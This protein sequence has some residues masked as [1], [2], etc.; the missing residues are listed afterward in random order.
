MTVVDKKLN[1]AVTVRG[2]GGGLYEAFVR[3]QLPRRR[4]R[5]SIR[6]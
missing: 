4:R 5:D 1:A 3:R 2:L 6:S